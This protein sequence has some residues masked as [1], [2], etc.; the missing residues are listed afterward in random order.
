MSLIS[1]KKI[2]AMANLSNNEIHSKEELK[3][4]LKVI[5]DYSGKFN[6][7]YGI[8]HSLCIVYAYELM[9]LYITLDC[10]VEKN[11]L[12]EKE[13]NR[14]KKNIYKKVCQLL[15]KTQNFL[16]CN[17]NPKL[18]TITELQL[19]LKLVN[20]KLYYEYYFNFNS[21]EKISEIVIAKTLFN[22]LSEEVKTSKNIQKM[23]LNIFGEYITRQL[24]TSSKIDIN[25]ISKKEEEFFRE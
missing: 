22:L 9:D 19:L 21:K 20:F 14:N 7:N 23:F 1:D 15:N 2:E 16:S 13:Y 25:T 12:S 5:N 17:V 3:S 18:I 11:S 24:Y 6:Y 10:F 4:L 8:G